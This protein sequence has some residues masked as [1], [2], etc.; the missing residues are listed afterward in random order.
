MHR[1]SMKKTFTFLTLFLGS[2]L[3]AQMGR[4]LLR[5]GDFSQINTKQRP[6]A[7]VTYGA[8][9]ISDFHVLPAIRT[10]DDNILKIQIKEK[11]KTP[12]SVQLRQR[13]DKHIE[14]NETVY[15][16]FSFAAKKG[17]RFNCYLQKEEA[18]WPKYLSLE[19]EGTGLENWITCR[20][21]ARI[22][23][24]L[25][26]NEC[27]LCFHLSAVAGEI[28][29]K[30]FELKAFPREVAPADLPTTDSP[31]IGG[32]ETNLEWRK[33][34][35]DRMRNEQ[36][37]HHMIHIFNGI[38]PL[39][40][41]Q[42]AI[43]QI[44]HEFTFGILAEPEILTNQPTADNKALEEYRDF[45][46]NQPYFNAVS[47]YNLFSWKRSQ[48]IDGAELKEL[49]RQ[50]QE[51][52]KSIH[53]HAVYTPAFRFMPAE[54]RQMPPNEI[55]DGLK[56]F[57]NNS[58]AAYSDVLDS[59]SV[60]NSP[61]TFDEVYT[62]TGPQTLTESF[63]IVKKHYP[64]TPLFV[65]DDF[66]LS[67]STKM[68]FEELISFVNWLQS[69]G[70]PISGIALEAKLGNPYIAPSALDQRLS[71]I[72]EETGL[73][74]Y[75]YGLEI[76]A[77]TERKQAERMHDALLLFYSH[78][79][80]KALFFS[81]VWA[82]VQSQSSSTLFHSDFVPKPSANTVLEFI[83]KECWTNRTASTG[84]EGFAAF[85]AAAGDYEIT[86]TANNKLIRKNL[87]IGKNDSEYV[88]DISKNGEIIPND[89]DSF[90]EQFK[91]DDPKDKPAEETSESKK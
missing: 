47:F 86:I 14:R 63:R 25:L 48:E 67:S 85:R 31:V 15:I 87:K 26:E 42:V 32:D 79:S 89:I 60:I 91:D 52:G 68:H 35:K 90:F 28:H 18:P 9:E 69:E 43:R 27:S 8:P 36:Q 45:I 4:P 22:P 49:L 30:N 21:A 39:K 6:Q 5:N 33:R 55:F 51:S 24:D 58:F 88:I 66:S 41:A 20:I 3:H 37:N 16:S 54:C 59:V 17:Y 56:N 78:P 77:E 46:F 12:W 7:W 84:E 70:A 65:C 13:I 1:F 44:R 53:G 72:A 40:G 19:Q 64:R 11:G 71:L 23:S 73:P 29:L 82:P 74:I 2:L 38:E 75:I 62:L 80:V 81:N 83:K 10:G 61:L 57:I 34:V 50:I 76:S